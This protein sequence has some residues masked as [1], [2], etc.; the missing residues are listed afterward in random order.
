MNL[1]GALRWPSYVLGFENL[2]LSLIAWSVELKRNVFSTNS[3]CA[4]IAP[5]SLE[6][7]CRMHV[8]CV[9]GKPNYTSTVEEQLVCAVSEVVLPRWSRPQ[10]NG[11]GPWKG[12]FESFIRYGCYNKTTCNEKLV[13]GDGEKLGRRKSHCILSHHFASYCKSWTF[14]WWLISMYS[15]LPIYVLFM[16]STVY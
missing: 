13:R 1:I 2:T 8:S 3:M 9:D 14:L 11:M 12:R 16:V 10:P 7:C 15:F 4:L 6:E 5:L